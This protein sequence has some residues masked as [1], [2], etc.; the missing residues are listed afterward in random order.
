MQFKLVQV[1]GQYRVNR[2]LEGR[3]PLYIF[4]NDVESRWLP[5]FLVPVDDVLSTRNKNLQKER[6]VRHL[7]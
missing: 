2:A 7:L 1:L 3:L 4:D 5:L 6:P